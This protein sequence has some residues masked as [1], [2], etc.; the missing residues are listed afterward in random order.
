MLLAAGSSG[1]AVADP[2]THAA[3]TAVTSIC[4]INRDPAAYAGKVVT[5]SGIYET[6]SMV[7]EYIEGSRCKKLNILP[8]GFRV[9]QRDKSVVAFYAATASYCAKRKQPIVCVL[10]GS[11]TVRGQIVRTT[12]AHLQPNAVVYAINLYSVTH[13]WLRAKR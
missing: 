8:V 4:A 2:P 10:K 5:V 7:Y 12:G 9:P 11:I 3:S 13:D 1:H 6:D